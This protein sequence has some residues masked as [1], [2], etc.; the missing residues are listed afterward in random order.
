MSIPE[1]KPRAEYIGAGNLATYSFDFNI[2]S[3]NQI[4]TQVIDANYNLIFRVRGS[5]ITNV[6][7]VTYDPVNGKGSITLSANLAAGYFLTI[8]LAPDSPVQLSEF[9]NK[10]DFTLRRLEAALDAQASVNQRLMYMISRAIKISDN[11]K[12][13]D[14]F[15]TS[16][17]IN[18]TDPLLQDRA[19]KTLVINAT[20][21]GFDLGPSQTELIDAL[22]DAIEGIVMD[23]LASTG[24]GLPPGGVQYGIL[25][26]LSA[27]SGDADWTP[28]MVFQGISAR[29][30][31]Q[32]VN[33]SG[34]KAAFD[35]LFNITYTPP[36]IVLSS[37]D[38]A[39]REKGTSVASITL[40]ATLAKYSNPIAA[41][42]FYQG[43]SQ[44]GS[45]QF[46]GGGIPNGG[47]SSQVYSV[48]FSNNISFTA[49]TEDVD[50]GVPGPTQTSNT[51]TFPF[52]Y[53]YYKGAGA[54]GLT[55]AQVA[56]LTKVVQSDNSNYLTTV[57]TTA[58]Q[59]IYFAYPAAY[60]AL[61]SILDVNGFETIADWTATTGNITGLDA[62]SQSYRIYKLNNPQGAG[63]NQYTFK[64]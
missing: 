43:A 46:S 22:H 30:G 12:D 14:P 35:W 49:Q 36:T 8:L 4:I 42:R 25:E 26:K 53:P 64:H 19:G 59:Y 29:F 48:P 3:A 18:T 50:M 54:N 52:V 60:A 16:L 21:N 23:L 41:V 9:K 57:T 2:T 7:M 55:P 6:A 34:V 27:T 44:I 15:D 58:G 40:I 62:T 45:T 39:L 28:A 37:P 61:N 1:Y 32:A 24:V 38:Y 5:D 51:L 20:N 56:A 13:T 47:S 10:A 33:L 11:L 63:S 17:P 31:N